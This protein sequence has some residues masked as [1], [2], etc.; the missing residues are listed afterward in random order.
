VAE[1]LD[2]FQT[3]LKARAVCVEVTGHL[4]TV[5]G[6]RPALIQALTNLV[7]N[8]LQHGCTARGGRVE[9]SGWRTAHHACLGVRDFG[10]GLPAEQ[11]ERVFD[12]SERLALRQK[13]AGIGLAVVSRIMQAHGGRAWVELPAGGGAM[14]VLGFPH[15]PGCEQV[16]T[17]A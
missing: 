16:W 17:T 13:G 5:A 2:S 3:R 1:V 15:V 14:F 9:I 6:A 12:V 11:R 10:P 8:A 7:A 4:P